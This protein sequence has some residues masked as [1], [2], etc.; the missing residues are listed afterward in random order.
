M[1]KR[2]RHTVNA[3]VTSGVIDSIAL[4]LAGCTAEK[5]RADDRGDLYSKREALSRL[6]GV[7]HMASD[8]LHVEY[9]DLAGLHVEAEV[10]Y[11]EECSWPPY[12][13][14]WSPEEVAEL[15]GEIAYVL[16]R[17]VTVLSFPPEGET[18]YHYDVL[19]H[20]S[21]DEYRRG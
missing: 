8:M 3:A 11:A 17:E 1:M 4:A 5:E 19:L 9:S 21:Q 7:R 2:N 20:A 15:A 6:F 18:A 10:N 12:G 16:R 13:R 14:P